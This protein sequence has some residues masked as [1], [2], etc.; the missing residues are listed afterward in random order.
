MN[1]TLDWWYGPLEK[2]GISYGKWYKNCLRPSELL[3]VNGRHIGLTFL[4]D[5]MTEVL[6]PDIY[7]AHWAMVLA[8]ASSRGIPPGRLTF[9][10]LSGGWMPLKR[11]LS[12]T[13]ASAFSWRI[14]VTPKSLENRGKN[15]EAGL[16]CDLF[17]APNI[18]FPLFSVFQH[19]APKSPRSLRKRKNWGPK[20]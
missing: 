3:D 10:I 6:T 8:S 9:W 1:W 2:T 12:R 5:R 18:L 7:R 4:I 14:T 15:Q 16:L 20:I 13:M 17:C 19:K 11:A